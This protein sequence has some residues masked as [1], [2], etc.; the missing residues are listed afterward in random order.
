MKNRSS[1]APPAPYRKQ[2]LK[3]LLPALVLV[4]C[5]G[6]LGFLHFRLSEADEVL[7]P[8]LAR[9]EA[10]WTK[11][12]PR[13]E[14]AKRV[15]DR[16]EAFL[17]QAQRIK[18]EDAARD[19]LPIFQILNEQKNPGVELRGVSVSPKTKAGR[20]WRMQ[21]DGV[22]S[23]TAPRIVM[24]AYRLALQRALEPEFQV[25]EPLQLQSMANASTATAGQPTGAPVAFTLTSTFSPKTP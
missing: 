19:W 4:V 5:A 2:V 7:R 24:E 6:V 1:H 3:S 14:E 17:S 10:E 13:Q 16:Y 20:T 22:A 12:A 15:R 9:L 11:L 8:E 25:D 21:V 23:G 18:T